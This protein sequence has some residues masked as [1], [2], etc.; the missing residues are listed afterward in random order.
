MVRTRFVISLVA[1]YSLSACASVG[2]NFAPM[3]DMRDKSQEQYQS[4]LEHCQEYAQYQA[5]PG[6]MAVVG[7]VVF[8]LAGAVLAFRGHKNEIADKLAIVGAAKGA[9]DGV[10]GQQDVIRRCMSA[11]GYAVLN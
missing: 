9:A 7:A 6:A 1:A 4:D 2:A 11:R 5:G 3:V 8:G 10:A